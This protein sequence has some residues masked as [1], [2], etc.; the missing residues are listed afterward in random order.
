MLAD[1][2]RV[3][4]LVARGGMSEVYRGWDVRLDRRVAVK[5]LAG[6][7]AADGAAIRRMERE[8]RAVARLQHPNVV[9]VYDHGEDDGG[10]PFLVMEWIEGR[11]LK[12][13]VADGPLPEQE[14]RR[15]TLQLLA[16]LEHA[17]EHGI[18]HRDIKPQNVLIT[19][20]GTAKLTDFG[21]ARSI[22]ATHGLT[23]AGQIV[24]TAAYLSPEQAKGQPVT[25]ASDVY[26]VGAVLF[27]LIT[28]RPPFAADTAMA[29]ALMHVEDPVP[30]VRALRRDASPAIAAV[31]ARAMA[32][33]PA[34]RYPSAAAMS[35]ALT[36]D[37]DATAVM[38]A[39]RERRGAGRGAGAG[40]AARLPRRAGR[41]RS[42][43]ARRLG[44]R[45]A[46]GRV[47]AEDD[48]EAEADVDPLGGRP[49]VRDGGTPAQ[50]R[51]PDPG[52][53]D[54]R[55][56]RQRQGFRHLGLT[57]RP[58]ARGR[59]R[60]ADR[61]ERPRAAAS[62]GG[63]QGAQE[64]RTST[65]TTVTAAAARATRARRRPPSRSRIRTA[66]PLPGR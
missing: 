63:G 23:M 25:A 47:A 45:P 29:T 33:R 53:G 60:H 62:A 65:G 36:E 21:I 13:V 48:G 19:P 64:A 49:A 41:R 12:D 27:E 2:Y 26:S 8:A 39:R 34:D 46:R 38:P 30:D 42:M 43:G 7:L 35:A 3:D 59:D 57:I 11:S 37:A 22:D 15:I 10:T 20:D 61:V 32:K 17:H 9:A 58:G 5:V 16:A 14:A 1:R 54:R 51:R 50:G 66:S 52:A 18:V 44:R 40:R 4:E 56:R 24:G 55:L 31:V 28:G 6:W